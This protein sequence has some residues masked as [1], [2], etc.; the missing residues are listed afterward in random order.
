MQVNAMVCLKLKQK[1]PKYNKE[2]F[3]NSLYEC[4]PEYNVVGHQHFTK[5]IEM[6]RVHCTKYRDYIVLE[7]FTFSYLYV[8]CVCVLGCNVKYFFFFF[9]KYLNQVFKFFTESI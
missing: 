5:K 6:I 4:F 8:L 3:G 1:L 2:I 9:K 7:I